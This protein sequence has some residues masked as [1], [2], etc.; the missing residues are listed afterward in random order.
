MYEDRTRTDE[1]A[2]G[3]GGSGKKWT[4]M[5]ALSVSY[6][7]LY[8]NLSILE[9]ALLSGLVNGG[10]RQVWLLGGG[11][12]HCSRSGRLGSFGCLGGA[13]LAS[14]LSES[15]QGTEYCTKVEMQIL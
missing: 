12:W 15:L 10:R 4:E 2:N 3:M 1:V 5:E 11:H 7:E 14:R 9:H 8:V 13:V 6:S